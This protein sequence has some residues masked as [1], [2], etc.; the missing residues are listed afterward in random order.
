MGQDHRIPEGRDLYYKSKRN[1]C[2]TTLYGSFLQPS[3]YSAYSNEEDSG[4][5]I[6]QGENY[7]RARRL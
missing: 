1:V 6:A 4:T 3:W 2:R 5:M 7:I